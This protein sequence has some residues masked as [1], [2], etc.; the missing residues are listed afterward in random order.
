VVRRYSDFVWFREALTLLYPGYPV[1][2]V[3]KKGNYK[4]Y[5][6][7]YLIKKMLI[8]EKFL[9]TLVAIPEL[10]SEPLFEKFLMTTNPK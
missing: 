7:K 10:F 9:N 6:D 8:L 5:D 3:K 4:R 1:P 2:P